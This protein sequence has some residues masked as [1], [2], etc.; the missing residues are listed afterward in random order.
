[1]IEHIENKFLKI[2]TKY[3][4]LSKS[5]DESKTKMDLLKEDIENKEKAR[6]ILNDVAEKTQT[7]FVKTVETLVTSALKAVYEKDI[8]F[9][10]IFERKRNKIECRPAIFENGYF[11]DIKDGRGGGM[12]PVISFAL[13]VVLLLLSKKRIRKTIILDEPVKANLS[14]DMLEKAFMMFEDISKRMGIQLIIITHY[15]FDADKVF[16][17]GQRNGVSYVE[18]S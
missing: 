12:V 18:L 6:I 11:Y 1:M 10:F 13:R 8:Q 2:E 9:R 3:D 15:R 5:F 17:I 7:K 16:E 4:I 14:G